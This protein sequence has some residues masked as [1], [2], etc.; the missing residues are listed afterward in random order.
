M[1]IIA[2]DCANSFVKSR[3]IEPLEPYYNTLTR[4]YNESE[5]LEDGESNTEVLFRFEGNT[6]K[7]GEISFDSVPLSDSDTSRYKSNEFRVSTIIAAA[8]H[9]QNG[10]QYVIATGLPANH[11]KID[12]VHKNV[13]DALTG[14]HTVFING[15]EVTFTV[16]DVDIY[17]QPIGALIST[18]YKL[19]GSYRNND[20]KEGRKV[21]I[22]IGWG[23][24]DVAVID[25]MKLVD[26]IPVSKSMEDAYKIVDT[27]LRKDNDALKPGQFT[28]FDLEKQLRDGNVFKYGGFSY[29]ATNAKKVGFNDT[30]GAIM[31]EVK[32]GVPSLDRYEMVLFTGGGVESLSSY[33]TNYLEEGANAKKDPNPQRSIVNGY[34]IAS[35]KK[36]NKG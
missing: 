6:Y 32:A 18:I 17:L 24:T 27:F 14:N 9:A 34:Y 36:H 29:N 15:E 4:V 20:Y 7:V 5:D 33:L 2:I 23:S 10:Q 30:A 25:G 8:Q 26:K 12:S 31:R 19:D 11:Y 35:N 22:D 13:V 28:K 16:V 3:G 1:E 21:I